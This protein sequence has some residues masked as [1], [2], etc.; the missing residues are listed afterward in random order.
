MAEIARP[1]FVTRRLM[2]FSLRDQRGGFWS[3]FI[4]ADN[5]P[6][7]TLRRLYVRLKYPSAK[8]A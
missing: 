5:A 4:A 2:L 8:H 3:L 6:E 7:Q 1:V